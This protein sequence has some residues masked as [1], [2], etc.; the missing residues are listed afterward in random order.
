MLLV[1]RPI[2]PQGASKDYELSRSSTEVRWRS[3]WS[4]QDCMITGRS[5]EN[6]PNSS[7]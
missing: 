2:E 1:H 4:S 3:G 7:R 5:I 6:A